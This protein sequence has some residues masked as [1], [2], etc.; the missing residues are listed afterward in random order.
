MRFEMN[1]ASKKLF[2]HLRQS[3]FLRLLRVKQLSYDGNDEAMLRR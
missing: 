1:R 3:D 2:R